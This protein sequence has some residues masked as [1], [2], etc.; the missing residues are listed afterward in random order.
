M[1]VVYLLWPSPV[2][3]LLVEASGGE[4]TTSSA[5]LNAFGNS[6]RNLTNEQR[7]V[8][9]IGDSFF[10]Q[11]WVTA[12]SSTNARDGLGPLLNAQ[13]C[14]SC[15][16][17]DGR[18]SPESGK[19]GL[20]MRL[21]VPGDD[22]PEPDPG[23]GGQLQD[24]SILG[25]DP[26]GT[27][28]TVY[29]DEPGEYSNGA[30]Y[31]LRRP[32]H[33]IDDLAY[34]PLS[35]D[36]QVSPRL[37][38]PVFGA[39]LLEAIPEEAIRSASDP[40][41]ED[42]DGISGRPN[43]VTNI[44]T[45]ETALGRFGWKA[46]VPTV[47]QQ[48][49]GA[50]LGDIGITSDLQPEENCTV[51]QQACLDALNGGSPE[52]ESDLFA[53]VVSYNRTLAV[54]ARRNLDEPDVVAGANLFLEIGCALCHMPRHETG[55]SDIEALANQVIY[56][57]TDLLLHDMGPDLADGRP[58]GLANGDEWRTAPL[59]GL[60]LND[61]VNDHEFYLHDGRAR[62]VE[63]AILWHGGEAASAQIEFRS[64][65]LA[66]RQQLLDFLESL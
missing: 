66:Q 36:V 46:S 32:V 21:S 16:L 5:D 31:T 30:A 55:S 1:T 58:D 22:G 14:S 19:P 43:Y 49:A 29:V 54:P 59:W 57:Y 10:T 39:G 13:S 63:E 24:R 51:P 60:G 61:V 62:S 20:L 65:S 48:V 28:R 53:A 64:L 2:G 47:A 42:G 41:D 33:E 25:I 23:Y 11:N 12:P 44:E 3:E 4:G 26:E 50:F 8:F 27:I 45:G 40:G 35:V 34:G 6:A 9:E 7:R 38:P 17:R 56:P 18:G 15:H 52:I 37:A